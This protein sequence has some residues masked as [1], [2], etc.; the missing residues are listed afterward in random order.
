MAD[1]KKSK[2]AEN[3]N[4]LLR[5][6]ELEELVSAT[7]SGVRI[8]KEGAVQKITIRPVLIKGKFTYQLS[9]HAGGQVFHRNLQ[10]EFCAEFIEEAF[11]RY[12]QGILTFKDC[13]RHVLSGKQGNLTIIKSLFSNSSGLWIASKPRGWINRSQVNI[14]NMDQT[15]IFHPRELSRDSRD[16]FNLQTGSK[17]EIHADACSNSHNRTKNHV[18]QD[19][20]PIPFLIALGIMSK[21]GSVLAKK[22]D[23]FRQINR[24]LEMVKDV[25]EHFPK[26]RCLSVVDFGCGKA[27]LTFALHYYLHT[28]EKRKVRMR[29]ID[30]KKDVI[31]NCQQLSEHLDCEGLTFE[32]GDIN[33]MEM[34]ESV[35]LMVALHACDT[36][37]DAALEKAVRW[38][39]GVILSVPCC[40]HELYSQIGSLKLETLLRHG[41]LKERVAALATDAAR[42]ELL[43]MLGYEV[44]ILEFIDMEHTPKNLLLRAVK[45]VSLDK[46]KKAKERYQ[47][48]KNEL[49]ILPSLERRF[50]EFFSMD[51]GNGSI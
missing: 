38:N 25:I 16:R 49:N 20:T 12:K 22:Y 30:L 11:K 23:K 24:F 27:Y 28:I 15:A 13:Q 7:L 6:I 17:K 19:G 35:D 43:T 37:T 5:A 18:L 46:R 10:P 26:D 42:A 8:K 32:V 3:F 4:E 31:A 14:N 9:E 51:N 2:D 47:Q 41:I 45:G 1:E 39:T 33:A 40:Q 50:S 44:Q 36:A 29:G 21:E 34:N 48:F